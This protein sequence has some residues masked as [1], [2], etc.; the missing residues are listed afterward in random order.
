MTTTR[1]RRF[2]ETLGIIWC[3]AFVVFLIGTTILPVVTASEPQAA[4]P[5]PYA[6]PDGMTHWVGELEPGSDLEHYADWVLDKVGVRD[7]EFA[8]R[9]PN[10]Y[11]M[12]ELDMIGLYLTPAEAEKANGLVGQSSV[13]QKVGSL[14]AAEVTG[15]VSIPT[16]PAESPQ[17]GSFSAPG[18][19][20]RQ[21]IPTGVA[22]IGTPV[23]EWAS[24]P[25]SNRS[26]RVAIIDTGI[27]ARHDDVGPIVGGYNCS[28]DERGPEGYG[29]DLHGHGTHVYG[30][31]AAKHNKVYVASI[32]P[33]VSVLDEITFGAEGSASGFMVLCALNKSLEHGADIISASLGGTHLP[34]HCGGISVYTNGWCKAAQRA[35]VVVAAGNSSQDAVNYGPA[36]VPGVITVGAVV[37]FDGKPGG[38]GIGQVGCGLSHRDDHLAIFSNWGSAVDVVAPGGCILSLAPFNGWTISSGTSMA[39]PHVTGIIAGFLGRFPDCRGPEAAKTVLSIWQRTNPLNDYDGWPG[40]FAPPMA[41]YIDERPPLLQEK[42]REGD[43]CELRLS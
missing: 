34:T 26:V 7:D 12:G 3:A 18:Q 13:D 28:Q 24:A 39:T 40:A 10:G 19:T 27:D 16:P 4:T 17:T 43:P 11:L 20:G 6:G 32:A 41:H 1:T 33:G 22:R 15:V 35:V 30:T 23:D 38:E 37:D 5:A 36:N 14:I 31:I 8:E 21:E 9:K 42:R 2:A 29:V 25:G